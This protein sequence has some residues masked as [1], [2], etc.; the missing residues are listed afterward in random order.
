MAALKVALE[1][2]P[3]HEPSLVLAGDICL[4]RSQSLGMSKACGDARAAELYRQ[5]IE[6]KPGDA[7]AWSGLSLVL[8]YSRRWAEA[9]E[10]AERGLA[11]ASLRL[12][13]GM[14]NPATYENVVTGLYGHRIRAL[15]ALGKRDTAGEALLE[16][17]A[18]YPAN[19]SL[20]GLSSVLRDEAG[21][22]E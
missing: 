10:A 20:G 11:V 8:L 13:H 12:G 7:T 17:L 18:L 16:G 21:P 1:L 6:I 4:F 14:R 2:D 3:T 19:T 15:L 9:L 22:D 5:A